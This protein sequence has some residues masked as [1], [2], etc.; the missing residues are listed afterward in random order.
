MQNC[1]AFGRVMH[2]LPILPPLLFSSLP[3][4]SPSTV[5]P[6]L[7]GFCTAVPSFSSFILYPSSFLSSTLFIVFFPFTSLLSRHL[8]S[9]SFLSSLLSHPSIL[10][11]MQVPD[12]NASWMDTFV[13]RFDQVDINLVMGSGNGLV[14]PVVKDVQGKGLSSISKEIAS[15]EDSL[16]SESGAPI[17]NEKMS[18]GT[19]SIHNLGN[20]IS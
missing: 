5:Y 9:L 20:S 12:V 19:F 3:V 17:A 6:R 1:N 11:P 15:F 14:T 16:F 18:I 4:N 8:L 10:P 13:R 2:F 7:L